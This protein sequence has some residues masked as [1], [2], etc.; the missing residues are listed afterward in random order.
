MWNKISH[1][2]PSLC[3]M[4]RHCPW[5]ILFTNRGS[6]PGGIPFTI[7]HRLLNSSRR[8]VKINP[9]LIAKT[10]H[11]VCNYR[12]SNYSAIKYCTMCNVL[13]HWNSRFLTVATFA[14]VSFKCEMRYQWIFTY[15]KWLHE[16]T[17]VQY[18]CWHQ[19]AKKQLI[20]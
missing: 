2:V 18:W 10:G 6:V 4:R 17:R 20:N 13:W 3:C 14:F 16:Y 1:V 8:L 11:K 7:K 12:W 5:K 15:I 19:M 9:P